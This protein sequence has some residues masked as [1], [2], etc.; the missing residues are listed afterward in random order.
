MKKM[1]SIAIAA[2]MMV[3]TT[4]IACDGCGCKDKADAKTEASCS[5]DKQCDK[6]AKKSAAG[7]SKD[8]A[9]K[10]CEKK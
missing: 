5:K 9:E 6:S 8:G 4:A 7:C 2:L 10:K 1:M 3:G